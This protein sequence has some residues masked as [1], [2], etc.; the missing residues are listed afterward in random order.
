MRKLI[1][2]LV[3]VLLV[4]MAMCGPYEECLLDSDCDDGR[5]C[6][7]DVCKWVPAA[8]VEDRPWWCDSTNNYCTYRDVDD[9]TPCEVD[10]RSGVCDAGE[11]RLD[12]ETPDG[13][14]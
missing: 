2:L 7:K 4:A 3:L 12:G 14:V 11:C 8:Y 9:G 1:L 5:A 10:E 13:G 6:T